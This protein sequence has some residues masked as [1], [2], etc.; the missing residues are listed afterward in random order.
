MK[1]ILNVKNLKTILYLFLIFLYGCED[2][3]E[4]DLETGDPQLVIDAEILWAKGT[5]GSEQT[6]KISRTTGYYNQETPKVSNAQVYVEDTNGNLFTFNESEEPGVYVC[7]NFIPH[8]N[9]TYTLEV[10]VEDQIYTAE[11]TLI[12][13]TP[14]N[15]VEQGLENDFSGDENIEVSIYYDDP[16][17]EI[18]YYLT[19]FDSSSLLYPEYI[20]T[21]DDLYDGNE[22]E[23]GI[24]DE[25]IKP[26]DIIEITHRGI[27]E[28]FYHYID[29]ILNAN[30]PSPFDTPPA[31]IRGNI[32]NPNKPDNYALGYFRLC[33]TN[34]LFYT[35][36]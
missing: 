14:I 27:S 5:D 20:E 32:V 13:V 29:L 26:G 30:D 35:V 8:L 10:T 18:N 15:R 25:E 24:D 21:S 34:H 23:D 1:S 19:S 17:N 16:E 4:L 33:E 9:E 22:I 28:Q 11:E 6:I 3:V 36:E 31:N 2:V 7:H 12:P